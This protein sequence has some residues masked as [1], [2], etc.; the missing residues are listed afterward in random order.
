MTSRLCEFIF[1]SPQNKERREDKS[2]TLRKITFRARLGFI[3]RK[4]DKMRFKKSFKLYVRMDQKLLSTGEGLE[5][6]FSCES[7]KSLFIWISHKF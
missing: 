4:Y 1:F 6:I 5:E 7:F 2:V 3:E